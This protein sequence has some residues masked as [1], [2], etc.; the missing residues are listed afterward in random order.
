MKFLIKN[1]YLFLALLS[2]GYLQISY[3]EQPAKVVRAIFTT[4]IVDREPIDQV[5]IL[6]N[7]T[8][9][10]SFFTELRHFEGQTIT[11]KWMYN[12][13]VESIV[14]FKVKGP[15]WRVYS[16]NELKPDQLGKWTVIVLDGT[17]RAIKASVF[18]LIDNEQQQVILPSSD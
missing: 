10:V 18:Q 12:D 13:K 1:S 7:K 15:R 9:A 8:L 2:C 16:R 3:A 6:G 4:K 14:Q 11:H 5:L 17:G